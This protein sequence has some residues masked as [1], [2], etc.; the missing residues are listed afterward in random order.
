MELST[1]YQGER[2]LAK[3]NRLL[4]KSKINFCSDIDANGIL[5]YWAEDEEL[6]NK[7]DA[8]R[9]LENYAYDTKRTLEEDKTKAKL[10]DAEKKKVLDAMIRPSSGCTRTSLRR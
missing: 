8:R 3:D 4:A 2:M 6:K 7:I 10:R 9:A 1:I 5:N